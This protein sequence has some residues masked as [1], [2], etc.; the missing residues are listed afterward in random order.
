MPWPDVGFWDFPKGHLKQSHEQNLYHQNPN[1]G[2]LPLWDAVSK[3]ILACCIWDQARL[4][5]RWTLSSLSRRSKRVFVFII[6]VIIP[7][8]YAPL[9]S[10]QSLQIDYLILFTLKHALA[11]TYMCFSLQSTF[12]Y[13]WCSQKPIGGSQ[14]ALS[15]AIICSEV[16]YMPEAWVLF[17]TVQVSEQG[18]W[19]AERSHEIP[20]T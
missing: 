8:K 19:E 20:S 18:N 4:H 13:F 16:F 2:F 10:L 3:I 1:S 11:D 6:I 7:Y 12:R 15:S 17:R 5:G 9:K 14:T